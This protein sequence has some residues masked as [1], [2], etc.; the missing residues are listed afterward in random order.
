MRQLAKLLLVLARQ[1]KQYFGG[2]LDL[3]VHLG[4]MWYSG[5]H[6]VVSPNAKCARMAH[7][8]F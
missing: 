1:A 5:P 2:K 4:E 8:I 7:Q 3:F 6:Q